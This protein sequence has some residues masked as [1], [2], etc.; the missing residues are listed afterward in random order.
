M[1]FQVSLLAL[2]IL[3]PTAAGIALANDSRE[4]GVASWYGTEL[5]GRKTASGEIFD[6][7]E[8]TAAHRDLPFGTEVKV[9][10]LRNG[11]ETVVTINDR[12]PFSAGRI[13]DLSYAAAKS[14]GIVLRGVAKVRIQVVSPPE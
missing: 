12:G 1:K 11:K 4:I 2:M 10:N 9:T 7:H 5:H 14:I 8:L 3:L 13:I 6:M